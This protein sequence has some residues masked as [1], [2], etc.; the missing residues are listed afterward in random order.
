MASWPPRSTGC[1]TCTVM[2]ALD[3]IAVLSGR[4]KT[5]Q[6]VVGAV[7]SRGHSAYEVGR[8]D[9]GD[10]AGVLAGCR[11][12][13]IMAPNMYRDEPAFTAAVLE[14]AHVNGITRIVYHSVAAPYAPA[15]PHHV[16]K[17]ESEDLV[18]RSG[19]RWTIL[20]PCAYIQ[21]FIA[22]I[23]A[24]SIEVAYD[25]DQRFGL[26]D[27]H[28]V[29]EAAAVA[30]TGDDHIGASYELGGP[31]LVS[32][33][34]VSR[35]ATGVLGREIGARR[36]DAAQWAQGPGASLGQRERD[37]LLAMF[38]YYD[39]YGFP[40]G[41]QSLQAVIGRRTRSVEDVLRNDVA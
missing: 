4:G 7:R 8:S 25:L 6:A 16:G 11:A 32:V 12:V 33:R 21:N 34:D 1:D 5:G 27:V 29:G 35:I 26:V 22:G 3:R 39:K 18:R 24:G 19:T 15:M 17:A 40:A 9:T 28:D 41:G 10:L 36:I 38:D 23:R 14:A 2:T 31:D 20:Q 30:L 13:Y 37:W